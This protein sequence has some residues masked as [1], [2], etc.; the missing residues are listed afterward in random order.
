[1]R[2]NTVRNGFCLGLVIVACGACGGGESGSTAPVDNY[3][4]VISNQWKNTRTPSHFLVLQTTRD[5]QPTGTFTGTE[6]LPGFASSALTGSWTNSTFVMSITRT[7]G[8]ASFN[9]K[10]LSADTMRLARAGD[11]LYFAK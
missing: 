4:P 5:R 2:A 11:T 8:T 7:A 1:M 6:T 3:L 9:G 10:F